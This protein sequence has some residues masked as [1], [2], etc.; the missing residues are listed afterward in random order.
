MNYS[1]KSFQGAV[2]FT[3][4]LI[5]FILGHLFC[6]YDPTT[7]ILEARNSPPSP[8]HWFGTDE[9]GRDLFART[10]QGMRISLTVGIAAAFIDLVLGTVWGAV[11]GFAR[12]RVDATMMRFAELVYSLPYLLVVILAT[13]ILGKGLI[14]I[15]V[16]MVCIGWIQMARVVRMLVLEA[17]RAE[18]AQAACALGVSSRRLF[19]S[20]ILPNIMG[21]MLAASM[22]SIPHAMFTE[23]FLSFLGIGMQPPVASLGSLVGDS[24]AAMRFFPWRLIFPASCITLLI[25]SITLLADGLRDLYDPKQ[26][27]KD[28]AL[29]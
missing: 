19:F 6:P 29:L 7:I 20:H 14:P 8:E 15:L 22:I 24:I 21:P 11:A 27:L 26:Q 17:R 4:L 13:V 3:T 25:F 10:L 28:G 16:A 1:S 2:L 9:L 18:Y 12:H 23:A 5:A